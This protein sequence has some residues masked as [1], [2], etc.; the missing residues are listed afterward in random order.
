MAFKYFATLPEGNSNM[1]AGKLLASGIKGWRDTC[2]AT[3]K[4][5][6]LT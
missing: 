6:E 2:P 4:E 3:L 1:F 5:K